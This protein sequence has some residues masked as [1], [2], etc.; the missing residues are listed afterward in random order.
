MD[1]SHMARGRRL[2]RNVGGVFPENHRAEAAAV[3]D[4]NVADKA[5]RSLVM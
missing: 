4:R 1:L 2:P 3:I 5:A